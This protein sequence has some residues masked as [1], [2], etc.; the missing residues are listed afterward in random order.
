MYTICLFFLDVNF[1]YTFLICIELKSTLLFVSNMQEFLFCTNWMKF[2]HM[3]CILD[4]IEFCYY[5]ENR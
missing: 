1:S 3:Q 5:F 4:F 2:E